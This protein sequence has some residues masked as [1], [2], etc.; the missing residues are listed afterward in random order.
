MIDPHGSARVFVDVEARWREEVALR[1][2]GAD[3][4]DVPLD[5]LGPRRTTAIA[6]VFVAWLLV[7]LAAGAFAGRERIAAPVRRIGGLSIL[8]IPTVILVPAAIGS[9][10]GALIPRLHLASAPTS[11]VTASQQAFAP[12]WITVGGVF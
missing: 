7:Y 11:S 9:A 8:W 3:K 5:E 10:A 6:F 2:E 4:V 12:T 1:S